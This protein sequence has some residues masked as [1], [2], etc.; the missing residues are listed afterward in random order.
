MTSESII[1][2]RQWYQ[3]KWIYLGLI[4]GL[5]I[6]GIVYGQSKKKFVIQYETV[7][8]VHGDLK[9]T[10]DATG[11]VESA[12]ELDLK[13]AVSGRLAKINRSAGAEVKAGEVLAQL[14]LGDLNAAV[15]QASA[16]LAKAQADLNKILAGNTPEYKAG[17]EAALDQA[18]AN[19]NQIKA[20]SDNSVHVAESALETAKNNLKFAE[21]GENSQIVQDAY[22][23]TVAL[24]KA[25]QS[26]LSSAMTGADN[27]LGIDNSFANDD[28]ESF[29]SSVN[30][31]KKYQAE[32]AY[33][34]AKN[35][36][37]AFLANDVNMISSH[38]EIDA[39]VLLA[40]KVLVS[41]KTLLALVSE[42][43]DNTRPVGNL[44][45]TELDVL[46]TNIKTAWTDVVTK[47]TSLVSQKQ[48]VLTAKNSYTS[49]SIAYQK[50][51]NDLT[52]AKA[53][54]TADIAS[55]EAAV[56]KAQATFDDAKNPPRDVDVA[57]YKA[58]V[59]SAY[60][61]LAQ[62][63]ANRDKGIIK[64]PVDGVIGKILPKVGEYVSLTDSIIK[65]VSDSFI[66]K[67]D[68]PE[69]D[70]VKIQKQNS[71]VV[72]YDAYGSD[73]KFN[74]FVDQ[75]EKGETMI[76]DV[77]YYRVTIIMDQDVGRPL[78]NGMT[79]NVTILAA[80]KEGVLVVPQRAVKTN[81]SGPYVKVLENGQPKEVVVELGLRGDGGMV[82]ILTGLKDGDEVVVGTVEAK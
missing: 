27:I 4:F 63:V 69:T 43:L 8:V 45:Q 75:I 35:D 53:K 15:A 62:A 50:A 25:V 61:S 19:L 29:L 20:S 28:F 59:S 77:I 32:F 2:Q 73:L 58:M 71:V 44:T 74:G 51:L 23:D 1:K 16:G 6:G 14:E 66:I 79:A 31:N 49:Y 76:Q 13:F 54:A 65:L 42:A 22:D 30:I 5:I 3:S 52:D 82:E 17:L 7:K 55:Y 46:K 56:A 33:Q 37:I 34:V 67:V 26:T 80:Q 18:K 36:R 70:V 78:F 21:G 10:V 48:A 41:A 68:I 39:S 64:A 24:I 47:Y 11:N 57:S 40:E 38:Q 60:A 72:T 9:Q 81:G 12:N